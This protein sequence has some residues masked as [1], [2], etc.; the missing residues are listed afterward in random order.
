MFSPTMQQANMLYIYSLAP[1]AGLH[2]LLPP[3][4]AIRDLQHS[5]L[6]LNGTA[7]ISTLHGD[8]SCEE[9]IFPIVQFVQSN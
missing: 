2:Y 9:A 4:G 6:M 8:K 7:C 1:H 5:V 3:R